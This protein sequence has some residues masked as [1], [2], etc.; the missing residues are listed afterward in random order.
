MDLSD[1]KALPIK[2]IAKENSILFMWITMP[3]LRI[4][5][6]R[7]WE[8]WGFTYKTCGFCW[9]KKNEKRKNPSWT[10]TLYKR[11]FGVVSNRDK[12]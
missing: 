1:I 7:S 10:R 6:F 3:M 9:N 4:K 8:A 2:N 11:E 12:G 5:L